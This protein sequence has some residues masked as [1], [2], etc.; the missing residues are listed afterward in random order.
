[1]VKRGYR[2]IM[3]TIERKTQRVDWKKMKYLKKFKSELTCICMLNSRQSDYILEINPRS[4][5]EK[6]LNI[7]GGLKRNST[8]PL[9]NEC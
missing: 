9:G 6:K 8:F 2:V 4:N 7:R 5:E 1:M 3:L